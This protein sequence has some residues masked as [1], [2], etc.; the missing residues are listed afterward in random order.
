MISSISGNHAEP[1]PEGALSNKGV[2]RNSGDGFPDGLSRVSPIRV[3]PHD[4]SGA[5]TAAG[6]LNEPLL[7]PT[8]RNVKELSADLSA[9]LADI[10][11][12]SGIPSHTHVLFKVDEKACR[13]RVE[14]DSPAEGQI[15]E[16]VNA[17]HDVKLLFETINAIGSHTYEMPKHIQ[18]QREYLA[19]NNPEQV[20]TKYSSLF[21][22]R[23]GHL[24]SM[25]Y[26]GSTIR[27][28]VDEKEGSLS[29]REPQRAA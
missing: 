3:K 24:L 26:N 23:P 6:L 29:S 19:S 20:I 9:K 15:E 21:G 17:D 2:H 13:I 12:R 8:A 27:M 1:V 18:F 5:P 11:S 4:L 7:L 16:L 22:P 25:I 14:S 10:F 28:I